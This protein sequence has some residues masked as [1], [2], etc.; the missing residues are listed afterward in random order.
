MK[1]LTLVIIAA[2]SCGTGYAKEPCPEE[3]AL[4]E[5]KKME[6]DTKTLKGWVRLLK[7]REKQN[8]A[9]IFL[10]K[11]EVKDL[12]KCLTEEIEYRKMTGKMK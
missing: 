8:S 4:L 3:K 1:L 9:G 5:S 11:E 7:N 10:T 2:L 12:I 6:L